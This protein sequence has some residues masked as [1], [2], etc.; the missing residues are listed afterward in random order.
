MDPT[1]DEATLDFLLAQ[2][3][4]NLTSAQKAD[5]LSVYPALAAMKARVRTPRGHM[6]EP[7]SIYAFAEE[8][9]A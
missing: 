6:A 4:L 1:L 8:D 5:L 3:G 2:S 7:S 9:L